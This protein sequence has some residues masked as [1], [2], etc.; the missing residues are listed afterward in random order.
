MSLPRSCSAVGTE[1]T[2]MRAHCKTRGYREYFIWIL[3]QAVL[4]NIK[5]A[6]GKPPRPSGPLFFSVQMELVTSAWL[7]LRSTK[8][9]AVL[10]VKAKYVNLVL[11]SLVTI[12]FP[13]P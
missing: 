10:S 12:P 1:L 3:G 2:A 8:H 4:I 5:A 6:L 7:G 11:L 13:A 9:L